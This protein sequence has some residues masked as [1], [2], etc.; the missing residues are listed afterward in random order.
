MR[1][2]AEHLTGAALP[3]ELTLDRWFTAWN[4]DLLWA[5]AAG[6]G[7]FLYLAGV[8]RLRRRGDAWPLYR[9]VLWVAGLALL[10]W[11]TVRRRSTPTR[12]TCS[13]CTWSGT[14]C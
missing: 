4:L 6:F 3:P 5:F 7:I 13:A 10:F 11:V 14:C 2:P 12:T 8:W 9:T 1:T